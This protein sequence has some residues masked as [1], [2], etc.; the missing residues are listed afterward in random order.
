[1]MR[2]SKQLQSKSRQHLITRLSPHSYRLTSGSSGNQYIINLVKDGATCSCKWGQSR[3]NG[4]KRSGCS[5]T[6]AVMSYVKGMEEERKVGC[7][8]SLEDVKRGKRQVVGNWDGIIVT[9][10]KS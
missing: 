4:D 9:A 6:L 5:H 3:P 7:C 2:N 8:G 10:R 1:M